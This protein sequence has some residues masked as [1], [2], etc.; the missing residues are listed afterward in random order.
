MSFFFG[1]QESSNASFF[2]CRF[3]HEFDGPSFVLVVLSQCTELGSLPQPKQSPP[4]PPLMCHCNSPFVQY[5]WGLRGGGATMY[6][7]ASRKGNLCKS[8]FLFFFPLQC[9]VLQ[10]ALP[11]SC[12]FHSLRVSTDFGP[13]L[14]V[15]DYSMLPSIDNA[16]TH[17]WH[18]RMGYQVLYM[19]ACILPT[20]WHA[21]IW[22][23][24][25]ALGWPNADRKAEFSNRK[26]K[27]RW[28]L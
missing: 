5:I 19:Y 27:T 23:W 13:S 16:W 20:P 8:V 14:Q 3:V 2:D 26:D 6:N 28:S 12:P 25:P 9:I 21:T 10:K 11:L 24:G 15:C 18:T 17:D 22:V 7:M 4:P 1:W